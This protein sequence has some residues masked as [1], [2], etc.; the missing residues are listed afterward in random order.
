MSRQLSPESC[1]QDLRIVASQMRLYD[2]VAFRVERDRAYWIP[3][4]SSTRPA[5]RVLL[6]GPKVHRRASGEN[7]PIFAGVALCRSDIADAAMAVRV[8][9]PMREVRRQVRACSRSAK[10]L[11]GNSGRY[12]ALRNK[13]STKALSS[14]TRGREYDGLTPSQ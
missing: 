11:A 9:G 12:L 10:P 7:R 3:V 6:P 4:A 2:G 1:C 13:D 14:E 8:V 5:S